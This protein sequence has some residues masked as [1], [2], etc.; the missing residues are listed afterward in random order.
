MYEPEDAAYDTYVSEHG[1]PLPEVVTEP[2]PPIA[3]VK[4][5]KGGERLELR[6]Y[7]TPRMIVETWPAT[8]TVPGVVREIPYGPRADG[9]EALNIM[10]RQFA[11]VGWTL[12]YSWT[13][14]S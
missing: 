5:C 9:H 6:L 8:R 1:D 13:A 10:I 3:I 12:A 11:L 2:F 7:A 14:R 4:L